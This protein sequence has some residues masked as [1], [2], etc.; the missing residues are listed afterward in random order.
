MVCQLSVNLNKIALI[1]NSR[2]GNNPS[3]IKAMECVINAGAHGI[4]VHPRPDERH[5]RRADVAQIAEKLRHSYKNIEFNIE[6]Y[7]DEAWLEL[8]LKTKP[9]Q[10][11]LVP[12]EPNQLTSDHGWNIEKHAQK[13][14][15]ICQKLNQAG[16]RVSLFI[17]P[18][19]KIVP[20][21]QKVG[22]A[23]MEL[24]TGIYAQNFAI[25][26]SSTIKPYIESHDIAQKLGIGINAGH[27]L[28]CDNLP[29]LRK[30]LPHLAEVSIG[31]ALIGD[32]LYFGFEQT[33]KNYLQAIA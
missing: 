9:D 18:D 17:D 25:S 3:V 13:L 4:T 19:P 28:N 2:L 8:V 7:P 6:G 30:N 5:I 21:V 33:I 11:T 12:D 1:R 16:I 22:A 15:N 31:H 29:Y 20:W 27:D 10:A 26:A 14:T 24:Y 23:R 32:A